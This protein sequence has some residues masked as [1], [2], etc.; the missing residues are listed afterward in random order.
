MKEKRQ[1]PGD[2]RGYVLLGI[3]IMLVIMGIFM[4]AAVPIWQH[5][6]QREREDE[7]IWRGNQYIRAIEL[8]QRKYPGAYPAKLEDLVEQKFLRKLYED[9][10]T[11]D[12]EW[13]IIRQLSPEARR[14]GTAGQP[15]GTGRRDGRGEAQEARLPGRA[16]RFGGQEG[17]GLG[18]IIGVVS[19]SEEESIRV[20]DGKE[21]Y[22]E[23]LFVYAPTGQA[24]RPPATRPPGAPAPPGA[25]RPPRSRRPGGMEPPRGPGQRPR[26][27]P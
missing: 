26:Q 16:S 3:V 23:W 20:L 17:Q 21:K 1:I 22:N 14:L 7:L 2:E 11:E 18:G 6:M 9:P 27:Q 24:G 13:K 15:P 19:K 4:G 5:M 25:Q 12:G 8:Y 10:M